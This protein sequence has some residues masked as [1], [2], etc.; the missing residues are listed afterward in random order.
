MML[1]NTWVEVFRDGADDALGDPQTAEE[2]L[3]GFDRVPMAITEQ[4][5]QVVDPDTHELRIVRHGIGRAHLGLDVQTDDRLHDLK[6]GKWWAV[7]HV[8]AGAP[9]FTGNR[10]VVLDLR[11]TS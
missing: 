6:S 3:A 10:H 4:A 9:S 8:E 7:G 1:A 11:T 2:P 5:I